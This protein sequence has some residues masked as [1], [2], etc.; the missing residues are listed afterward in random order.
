[1]SLPE[2]S[3]PPVS[4][5]FIRRFLEGSTILGWLNSRFLLGIAFA[6]I[7]LNIGIACGDSRQKEI[8]IGLIAPITGAIPLVGESSVNAANLAV[9][10]INEAGGLVV[11]GEKYQVVLI[12]EDNQ[13]NAEISSS[14]TILMANEMAVDVIVGPQASRNAI[15]AS[16]LAE[17]AQIPMI[18]PW[19]TNEETTLGKK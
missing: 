2:K 1:M 15:P 6:V 5:A 18:S 16:K 10:Q 13:D 3:E 12:I 17:L 19:S 7:L 11:D 9:D 8:R 14:K 4:P